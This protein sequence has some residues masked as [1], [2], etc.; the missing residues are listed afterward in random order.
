MGST[1]CIAGVPGVPERIGHGFGENGGNGAEVKKGEVEKEEVHGGVEVV[2]TDYSCD[3]EAVA[4]EGSQVDAQKESEVQELHLLCVCECQE[5]ELG[6]GTVVGHLLTLVV[7]LSV[8][9][10]RQY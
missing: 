3:D 10:A 8:G 2:V 9:K 4:E 6:D 5:E 7:L 1:S